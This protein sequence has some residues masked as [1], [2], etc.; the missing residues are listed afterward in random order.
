MFVKTP[1]P[2]SF[3]IFAAVFLIGLGYSRL[4]SQSQFPV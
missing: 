3:C 2:V 1:V 4:D